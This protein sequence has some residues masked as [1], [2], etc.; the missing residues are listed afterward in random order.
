MCNRSYNDICITILH[1]VIY[2]IVIH[3]INVLLYCKSELSRER[4]SCNKKDL[5]PLL[6][7]IGFPIFWAR[8]ILFCL[9]SSFPPP[10]PEKFP[11]FGCSQRRY[12]ILWIP[13]AWP[14]GKNTFQLQRKLKIIQNPSVS[15]RCSFPGIPWQIRY[16]LATSQSWKCCSLWIYE[17][18]RLGKKK[19]RQEK[20][21]QKHSSLL[22]QGF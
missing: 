2:Y 12:S 21:Q 22:S 17:L 19:S 16:H 20:L 1:R 3:Y 18:V 11:R 4:E 15:P 8:R 14:T 13:M 6:V 5:L 10:H 9:I 7:W